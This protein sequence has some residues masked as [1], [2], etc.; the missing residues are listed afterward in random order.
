[1]ETHGTSI[2]QLQSN[3]LAGGGADIVEEIMADYENSTNPQPEMYAEMP[4]VYNPNV[5]AYEEEEVVLQENYNNYVDENGNYAVD[6]TVSF[7]QPSST[8][9][10][11]KVTVLVLVLFVLFNLPI[12]T[13]LID[14]FLERFHIPHF[15]LIVR[16]LV[17]VVVFYLVK[18]F[19]L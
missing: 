4:P 6:T 5:D 12:L 7:N 17:V 10:N 15:S 9:D 14:P 19:L 1:M 11:I 16:T 13:S 8:M 3:Q 2:E 18:S